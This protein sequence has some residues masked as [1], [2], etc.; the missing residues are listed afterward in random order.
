MPV[1]SLKMEIVYQIHSGS[2]IRKGKL[3]HFAASIFSI[4][5]EQKLRCNPARRVHV[6]LVASAFP[7]KE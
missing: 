1:K 3:L 5:I 6:T 7:Q 4:F 2:K